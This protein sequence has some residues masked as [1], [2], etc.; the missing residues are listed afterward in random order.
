V[1]APPTDR[2]DRADGPRRRRRHADSLVLVHT[3][4]G[5]GKSTAAFGTAL[6]AVARGWRVTVVQFMK[7]GRWRVGEEEVGRRVGMTWW[8]IGDGF[9]WE[10]D[11]LDRSAAIAREAWRAARG[12]LACGEVDLLVLDE[13][14]YPMTYGWIDTGEVVAAIADRAPHTHVVCTGRNA[15]PELVAA[16]DTV[17]EMVKVKHAYD[18]GVRARRGIDY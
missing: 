14:T 16:A 17:T 6:R 15:A 2:A 7:S 10:S 3:G 1:T 9:T 4:H 11:D 13:I 8:T 5:K 18:A 12:A